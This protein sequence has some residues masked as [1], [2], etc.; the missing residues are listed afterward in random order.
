MKIV[1]HFSGTFVRG[2]NFTVYGKPDV[3]SG[4][5]ELELVQPPGL[6]EH[7][8]YPATGVKLRYSQKDLAEFIAFLQ[9]LV[10]PPQ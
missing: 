8:Y 9:R 7:V 1:T 6:E 5:G 10:I 2:E 4:Y 3:S